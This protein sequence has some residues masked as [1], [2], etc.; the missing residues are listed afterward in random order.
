MKKIAFASLTVA[1]TLALAACGGNTAENT[2]VTNEIVLN[3]EEPVLDGN[4]TAVDAINTSEPVL[5]DAAEATLNATDA[6]GNAVANT[7]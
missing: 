6:T 2:T 4:L 7:L 5:D 3:D 1:A